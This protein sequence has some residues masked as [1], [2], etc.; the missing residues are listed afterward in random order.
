MTQPSPLTQPLT[1]TALTDEQLAAFE[2]RIV[3][4]VAALI[5]DHWLPREP[6]TPDGL[7]E[8]LHVSR[9]TIRR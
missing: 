4:R 5:A 6:M 9:E 2:D 1:I 7:A 8:Y 3:E